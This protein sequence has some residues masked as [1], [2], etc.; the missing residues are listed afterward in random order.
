MKVPL[1]DGL[2]CC[3][4]WGFFESCHQRT[5]VG[6]LG[7]GWADLF[8]T[9]WKGFWIRSTVRLQLCRRGS[10][11]EDMGDKLAGLRGEQGRMRAE[12]RGER[13][14]GPVP[15]EGKGRGKPDVIAS[16]EGVRRTDC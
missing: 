2:S 12:G 10:V 1:D 8:V 13:H 3:E 5:S 7:L 4:G 6:C 9:C 14:V 11:V 15:W 16:L